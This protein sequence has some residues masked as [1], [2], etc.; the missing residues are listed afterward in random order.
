MNRDRLV[1][2]WHTPDYAGHARGLIASL[3]AVGEPFEVGQVPKLPG[4]WERNTLRK[5]AQLRSAM[6]RWPDRTIILLDVDCVVRRS[7]EPLAEI[8]GDVGLHVM[9]FRSK[10]ASVHMAVRSGTMVIRPTE[11]AR[12]FV[13]EWCHLSEHAPTG[14]VDQ[15]TLAQALARIPML[16]VVHIGNEW[17]ATEADRVPDPAI[18]HGTASRGQ[19]KTP[20]WLRRLYAM[21][22][23][24]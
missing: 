13:D 10:R 2:A 17:C 22:A 6:N 23:A 3:S 11:R 4:G 24:A 18:L 15:H 1:Y 19:S 8:A 12:A 7:L 14:A 20:K 21:R 9:P 5:A 16:G